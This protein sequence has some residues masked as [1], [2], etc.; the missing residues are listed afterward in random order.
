M[1]VKNSYNF[2]NKDQLTWL[3]SVQRGE[4]ENV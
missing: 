2:W 3:E 1:L 4:M